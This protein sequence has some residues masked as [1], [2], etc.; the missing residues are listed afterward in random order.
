MTQDKEFYLTSEG[1]NK[2]KKE[3]KALTVLRSAKTKGEV[4]NI[5]E[6]EDLNPEYLTF[7][8]D[9]NFLESRIAEIENILKHVKLIRHSSRNKK[10]VVGIG[11]KVLVEIDGEDKDELEILGTLEA[12]PSLG[13]ISNESPVGRALMGRKTGEEIVVSS[14]IKTVYKIKRIKY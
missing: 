4:P 13:R 3:Y 5:M 9:L 10:D 7:Q 6:S 11:A 8:E 14:P 12:N 1:I 2:L